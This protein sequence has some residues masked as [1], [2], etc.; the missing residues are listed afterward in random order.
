MDDYETW[1]DRKRQAQRMTRQA[2]RDSRPIE[3]MSN[4][5]VFI[6]QNGLFI[7]GAIISLLLVITL[8]VLGG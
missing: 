5:E 4:L 2:A 6:Q 8:A 1:R 3:D 7:A